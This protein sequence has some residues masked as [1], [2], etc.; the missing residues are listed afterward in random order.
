MGLPE[1]IGRWMQGV[2]FAFPAEVA[3][4]LDGAD[5]GRRLAAA[6]DLLKRGFASQLLFSVDSSNP[7]HLKVAEERSKAR[8]NTIHLLRH[9]A[10]S[11]REEAAWV[12]GYLAQKGCVSVVI[13][14]SWYQAR[15]TR[16]I[17]WRALRAN[18]I[19]V[20]ICPV[21]PPQ[22]GQGS[23][24]SDATSDILLEPIRLFFAWLLWRSPAAPKSHE[25]VA[26]TRKAA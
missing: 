21:R 3:V 17:F 7:G 4:V 22:T 5:F 12:Q 25:E 15:R 1:R 16:L 23:K 13:V 10:A 18:G 11:L 14:T 6:T 19:A 9:P 2:D 24:P 26:D 8:P 20:N